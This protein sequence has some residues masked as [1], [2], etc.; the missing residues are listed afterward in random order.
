MGV[1]I[2]TSDLY[3]TYT[4]YPDPTWV[5]LGAIIFLASTIWIGLDLSLKR[6]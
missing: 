1:I 6:S 2:M 4:S 3:W 5:A